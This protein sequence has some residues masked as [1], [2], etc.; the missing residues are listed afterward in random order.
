MQHEQDRV[1]ERSVRGAA[2]LDPGPQAL[3]LEALRERVAALDR[4]DDPGLA[5]AQVGE[6]LGVSWRTGSG[7][8]QGDPY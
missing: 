8:V 5:G 4:R 3:V 7:G 6:A 2:H 1:A